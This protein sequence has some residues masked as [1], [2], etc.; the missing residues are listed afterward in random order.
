MIGKYLYFCVSTQSL[1]NLTYAHTAGGGSI[2]WSGGNG[3]IAVYF[4][5]RNYKR[6]SKI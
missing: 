4:E 3:G 5:K 2:N 1:I 6:S